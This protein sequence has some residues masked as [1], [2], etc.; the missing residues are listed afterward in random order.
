MFFTPLYRCSTSSSFTLHIASDS[1]PYHLEI[2]LEL[3]QQKSQG[4]VTL[5]SGEKVPLHNRKAESVESVLNRKRANVTNNTF[6][7]VIPGI[8]E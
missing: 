3:A 2:I 6:R 5:K 7:E 4:D 1:V 8:L